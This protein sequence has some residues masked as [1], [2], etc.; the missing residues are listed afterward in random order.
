M[1]IANP[2]NEDKQEAENNAGGPDAKEDG[3]DEYADDQ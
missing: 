1:E 2:V 3:E